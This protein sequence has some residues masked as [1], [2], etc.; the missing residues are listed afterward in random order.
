MRQQDLDQKLQNYNIKS[1]LLY[2]ECR[3]NID[4]YS[5]LISHRFSYEEKL[6]LYFDEYTHEDGLKHLKQSS[7]FGD[8][9]IL[10]V[11]LD[12]S[13][14]AK[15]IREIIDITLSNQSSFFIYEFYEKES[16]KGESKKIVD[17]FNKYKNPLVAQVRFFKPFYNQAI[18]LLRKK[19][20]RL[21][22]QI[23]QPQLEY[24]Y[25]F[26]DQELSFSASE[27]DKL[28]ILGTPISNKDIQRLAVN[29]SGVNH[30]R[31]FISILKKRDVLSDIVKLIQEGEKEV[32]F[33]QRFASFVK[34][35]FL[36]NTYIKLHG[37]ANSKDI[38]GYSPPKHIEEPR[39]NLAINVLD[40]LK[41][42]NILNTL[43]A[44][45]LQLKTN[46]K[47]DKEAQ[48]LSTIIKVQ[49]YL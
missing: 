27:L 43:L 10:I 18:A 15:E 16:K 35:I 9:N 45:E 42:K 24:L 34:D 11:K 5:R 20:T 48:L 46:S 6:K 1:I 31:L 14:G 25:T 36:Y 32:Q 21:N 41:I 22:I 26:F 3:F 44:D 28:A 19:A 4:Y 8:N 37:S 12:S 49:G 40:T 30:E 7:L 23:Q 38:F 39:I 47:I 33:I 29:V 2:G 13:L 17:I